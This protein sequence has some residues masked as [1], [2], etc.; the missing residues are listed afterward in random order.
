MSIFSNPLYQSNGFQCCSVCSNQQWSTAQQSISY[1]Q[2]CS[3]GKSYMRKYTFTSIFS[4]ISAVLYF[5]LLNPPS[6]HLCLILLPSLTK[7]L[8]P[9]ICWTTWSH[10]LNPSPPFPRLRTI[11][12]ELVHSCTLKM[13]ISHSS[14]KQPTC[15]WRQDQHCQDCQVPWGIP[16]LRL[17]TQ[18]LAVLHFKWTAVLCFMRPSDSHLASWSGVPGDIITSHVWGCFI[19]VMAPFAGGTTYLPQ[20]EQ[21]VSLTVSSLFLSA[22]TSRTCALHVSLWVWL[23]QNYFLCIFITSI[24]LSLLSCIPFVSPIITNTSWPVYC[25]LSQGK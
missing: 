12:P 9:P 2:N 15:T 11:L 14:V 19:F 8:L 1:L 25:W 16:F 23:L 5:K 10:S 22:E 4:L 24:P 17:I 18:A 20:S 3:Q 6:F 7:Q 13:G 21:S